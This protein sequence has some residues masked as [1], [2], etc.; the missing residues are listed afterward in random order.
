MKTCEKATSEGSEGKAELCS[1][2]YVTRPIQ[3][4]NRKPFKFQCMHEMY[5]KCRAQRQNRD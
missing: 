2:P 1:N 4:E 3:I 5:E